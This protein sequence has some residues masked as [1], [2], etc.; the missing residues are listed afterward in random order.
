MVVCRWC[1][2]KF[3]KN[4]ETVDWIMPA[5]NQ[6]Y[7]TKC[8]EQKNTEGAI[9]TGDTF[10]TWR[11]NIFDFIERDLKK[12]CNYTLITQQL[13][14]FK[15]KNPDWT[16]KGMFFA[17]KWFYEVKHG[18]WDK[19]NNGVGILPYIYKEGTSYWREMEQK[20]KG[21]VAQIEAQM[22]QRA[23]REV[24]VITEKKKG[25]PKQKYFLEE[26]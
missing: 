4:D 10:E 22:E 9:R 20:S 1:G 6:Y 13:K 7:H 15:K 2:E 8:L 21:I 19:S 14:N 24:I 25:R 23:N 18:N 17:L 26:E 16:Y 5:K 3:D 12:E 11:R